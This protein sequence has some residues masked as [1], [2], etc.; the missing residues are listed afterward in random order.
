MINRLCFVAIAACVLSKQN[1][2]ITKLFKG[3][4]AILM[5]QF[6]LN[7]EQRLKISQVN[8]SRIFH[9]LLWKV[10]CFS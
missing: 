6:A 9:F 8:V 1:P 5:K 3:H 7:A 4:L 10:I 2:E